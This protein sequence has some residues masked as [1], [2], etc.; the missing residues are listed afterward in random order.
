MSKLMKRKVA[1]GFG[2]LGLIAAIFVLTMGI[3]FGKFGGSTK[4]IK[5]GSPNPP[6]TQLPPAVEQLSNAFITVA[7]AVTPAVVQIRVTSTPKAVNVPNQNQPDDMFKFFFGPDF[8]FHNFN[9]PAPKPS[10]EKS[11]GSGVI[12]SPD[13][14]IITNNHVVQGADRDGIKVTLLDKRT[15]DAKLVG[16][17]P[18]TD[19]AVIKINGND[20]PVAS[21]GNSDSVHVGE[22]VVAIG[23]PLGLDYTVTQGIISALGRNINIIRNQYGIE[24]FIQ[25][26]AVINPGNSGGPLVDLKGQVVGINTAIATNTG[27][28][29]G[30][31]FAVPINLAYKVALDLIKHGKVIRPYIGVA[32]QAVDQTM[33]KA[34]GMKNAQGV[35][36]Q[37]VES[38]SPAEE[39]G[40]KPGDVILKFDGTPIEQANQLQTLVASKSP[41]DKVELEILHDGKTEEKTVTL[42]ERNGE[43]FASNTGS[44]EGGTATLQ[45]LGLSVQ[46]ADKET[47]QKYNAK[48]GVLVTDVSP[49]SEAEDRNIQR[50]DLITSVDNKPISS[51]SDLEKIVKEH[52]PGDALLFRVITSNK[53]NEFLALEIPE[54]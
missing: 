54:K 53:T 31:G 35:L 7:H 52:K 21:L 2:A 43:E 46:N 39:A 5:L 33:A 26:D 17:D 6:I 16:R 14:Y 12:V 10:P 9:I 34:L 11:L 20:L 22:W 49:G 27:T 36:V 13:G 40:I 15:F 37:S 41:G 4:D 18:T 1:Y 48:H 30:Y 42:R 25:T 45:S 29:E 28:Y 3:T 23:N 19:I 50:G 51:V 24:D 47:L 38:N 44:S 8:P 32:I